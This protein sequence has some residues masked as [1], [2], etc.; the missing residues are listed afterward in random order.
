M[1]KLCL[2]VCAVFALQVSRACDENDVEE[3]LVAAREQESADYLANAY[4]FAPNPWYSYF[5]HRQQNP[6]VSGIKNLYLGDERPMPIQTTI[7]FRLQITVASTR[8]AHLSI[9]SRPV[10]NHSGT[11]MRKVSNFTLTENIRKIKILL[12]NGL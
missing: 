1:F 11:T 10:S 8:R 4:G 9:D 5:Y 2:I 12:K 3:Q 7:F 6:P